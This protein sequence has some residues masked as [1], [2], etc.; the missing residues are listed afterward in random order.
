[1][2]QEPLS[3]LYTQAMPLALYQP[4]TADW[5]THSCH[6]SRGSWAPAQFNPCIYLSL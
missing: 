1:M 2:G 6:L 5:L 3:L 4:V